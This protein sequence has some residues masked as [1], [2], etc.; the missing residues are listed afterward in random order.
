MRIRALFGLILCLLTAGAQPTTAPASRRLPLITREDLATAYIRAERAVRDHPPRDPRTR[1]AAHRAM[2]RA[3]YQFFTADHSG[4]IRTMNEL[5]DALRL[6]R[7]IAVDADQQPHP[8]TGPARPPDVRSVV[9]AIRVRVS[10]RVANIHRPSIFNVRLS[11]LYPIEIARPIDLRLL[12]REDKPDGKIVFEQP[13]QLRGDAAL[14]SV[15]SKQPAAEPGRYRV[16]LTGKAGEEIDVAKWY[17]VDRSLDVQRAAN[18]RRL[19]EVKQDNFRQFQALV[20][21]RGRNAL[22]TDRPTEVESSQF[23]IDPTTLLPEVSAEVEALRKGEDPYAGRLGDYWRAIPCGAMQVPSRVYVPKQANAGQP[24]PLVIILHGAGGDENAWFD[25]TAA[26]EIK[27]LAD[28][29]GFIVVAP[30]TY[31]VMPNPNGLKGIVETMAVDYAIDPA[32]IY[33]IG[34]SLGAMAAAGMATRAPDGLAGVV[35]IAGG[36]IPPNSAICPTLLIAAELDPLF[37]PHKLEGAAAEAKQAGL[38][39]EFRLMRESGH[40]LVAGE[41]L[42]EAVEWLLKRQLAKKQ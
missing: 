36:S 35:L 17:V 5:A 24:M 32:R 38:P 14:P 8:T 26:G 7:D 4:A 11:S 28:R 31:W 9:N 12:V 29:H 2:D 19:F 37:P 30:N 39:V 42:P 27:R 1:A 41:V 15:S 33:V 34:H 20:A 6:G 25:A 16:V 3:A 22:L 13:L 23:L 21:C 40:A 18:E 10:P